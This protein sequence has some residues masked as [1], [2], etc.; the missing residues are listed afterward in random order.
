MVK[1]SHPQDYRR[2]PEILGHIWIL[3]NIQGG[4][5]HKFFNEVIA[6]VFNG[7]KSK[8]FHQVVIHPDLQLVTLGPPF[9]N[10]KV[11]LR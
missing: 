3:R 2:N 6:P 5:R 7:R 4:P 10:I 9:P 11:T 1:P 8:G